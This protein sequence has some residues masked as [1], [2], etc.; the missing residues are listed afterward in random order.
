MEMLKENSG[1]S[2]MRIAFMITVINGNV[3]GLVGALYSIAKHGRVPEG[4]GILVASVLGAAFIGKGGQKFAE[5]M[6]NAN[7]NN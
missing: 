7:I 5:S 2:S 6:K 4:L 3:I 1:S